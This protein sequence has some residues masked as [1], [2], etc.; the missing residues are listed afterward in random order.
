MA[1][2]IRRRP[3]KKIEFSSTLK[4]LVRITSDMNFGARVMYAIE[5]LKQ[6]KQLRKINAY[7]DGVTSN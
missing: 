1:K 6:R 5:I 3:A 2:I 7:F 4:T